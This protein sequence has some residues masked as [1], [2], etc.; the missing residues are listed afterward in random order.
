[1][2]GLRGLY[3]MCERLPFSLLVRHV[4]PLL[5]ACVIR[6]ATCNLQLEPKGVTHIL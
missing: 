1:M 5:Q 6:E 3:V 2:S 4:C